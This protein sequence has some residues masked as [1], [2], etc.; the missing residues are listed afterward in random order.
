[1]NFTGFESVLARYEADAMN[2]SAKLREGW[3]PV[4][5]SDHPEITLVTSP[6]T[7]IRVSAT[8]SSLVA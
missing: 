7:M 3:E 4:K 5:A 2:V 1:M 6:R 8:T